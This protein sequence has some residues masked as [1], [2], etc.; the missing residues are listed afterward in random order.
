MYI[1]HFFKK[2]KNL[3]IISAALVTLLKV[4]NTFTAINNYINGSN[5][6]RNKKSTQHYREGTPLI[7]W[8][9]VQEILI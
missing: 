5:G 9:D 2:E 7:R 3:D 8:T 4:T 6:R 1:A